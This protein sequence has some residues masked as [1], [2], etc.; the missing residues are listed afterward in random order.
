MLYHRISGSVIFV[1]L[2]LLLFIGCSDSGSIFYKTIDIRIQAVDIVS[3]S[4]DRPAEVL[5]VVSGIKGDGCDPSIQ[6]V[7]AERFG[8]TIIL[9]ATGSEGIF[10][11]GGDCTSA[12]EATGG[13][14][15]A[16]ELE[17]GEY[18]VATH[19]G[20]ELLHFR[21]EKGTAYVIRKSR[22]GAITVRAKTPEGI[23]IKAIEHPDRASY[24]VRKPG[25]EDIPVNLKTS[26]SSEGIVIEPPYMDV[27][28]PEPVQVSIDMERYSINQGCEYSHKVAIE[29]GSS[30]LST[31][32]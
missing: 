17:V 22:I 30:V 21:I 6:K 4:E 25:I 8:N 3:I 28:T 2:V 19:G 14:I 15:V 20:R 12:V 32:K 24:F 13:E 7:S 1:L 5:F 29:K 18:K 23:L 27:Y 11:S 31:L 26:E 10:D 16:K 9:Q